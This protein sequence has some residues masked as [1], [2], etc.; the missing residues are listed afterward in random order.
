M[1]K[2]TRSGFAIAAVFAAAMVPVALPALQRAGAS[3]FAKG[4]FVGLFLGASILLIILA[5][6]WRQANSGG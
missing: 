4:L 2:P 6:R 3:D 1:K 5:L